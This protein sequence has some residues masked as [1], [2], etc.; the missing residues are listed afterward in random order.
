M[1]KTTPLLMI[2]VPAMALV[3]C[4]KYEKQPVKDIAEIREQAKAQAGQGLDAPQVITNEVNR[5]RLVVEPNDE[6]PKE[7]DQTKVAKI[8]ASVIKITTID[9]PSFVEGQKKVLKIRAFTTVQ[10]V[11]TE[12]VAVSVPTGAE[13]QAVAGEANVYALT[14]TAPF[15]TAPSNVALKVKLKIVSAPKEETRQAL[16]AL[17]SLEKQFT[18]RITKTNE[19]LSTLETNLPAEIS[20]DTLTPF[21]V[22]VKV[23]GTD[24]KS[25]LPNLDVDD[26]KLGFVIKNPEHEK[27]EF[28]GDSKWR[29]SLIF[30]TKNKAVPQKNDAT[31]F[32]ARVSLK[33]KHGKNASPTLTKVIVIKITKLSST[34][35]FDM[36][37]LGQ[38]KLSLERGSK[39]TLK[40]AVG[41]MN[42]A[43]EVKVET[44]NLQTLVGS[45]TITCAAEKLNKQVCTLEWTVPCGATE[46]EL[47]NDITLTAQSIVEGKATTPVTHILKTIAA[48]TKNANCKVTKPAGASL[49][50]K[51]R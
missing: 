50:E 16:E 20:Q 22:T 43:V 9:E 51:K 42:P 41:A 15:N 39:K 46:K 12:L 49:Q 35:Q 23:P 24:E 29:F 31:A 26:A 13:L 2:M 38:P 1:K 36:K 44:P 11:V 28:L 17:P 33:A 40:F 32:Q 10:G 27:P 21:Q 3:A 6:K 47:Q 45:P 14:Y 25:A 4:G 7:I 48:K 19:E 34:P 8:D 30:D 37:A 18:L 5:T